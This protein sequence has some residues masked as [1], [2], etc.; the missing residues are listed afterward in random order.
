MLGMCFYQATENE[1]QLESQ[2]RKSGHKI[3]E[4]DTWGLVRAGSSVGLVFPI[5][6]WR[7]K[8]E[9]LREWRKSG[10]LLHL[11][12]Y[13]L[14]Q[15]KIW[16]LCRNDSLQEG[17]GTFTPRMY[18]RP[19]RSSRKVDRNSQLI[20]LEKFH[21]NSVGQTVYSGR[22]RLA[23]AAISRFMSSMP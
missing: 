20:T 23:T 3:N 22:Q 5:G 4:A 10:V 16:S 14:G 6:C 19:Q 21:M 17:A 15:R 11:P 9:P 2:Q 1:R 18:H 7:Q 8:A 12:L 13:D